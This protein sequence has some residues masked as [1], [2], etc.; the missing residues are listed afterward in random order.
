MTRDS[1]AERAA[2][3][4]RRVERVYAVLARIYDA[5]FDWALGPGRR[6]AI[7]RLPLRPGDR[8][9]E[10]GVGTGLSL[11]HYPADC[12]VTGI[13]ISEPM[14][15]QARERA[16]ELR[17]SDVDLRLMDARELAFADATFDHVLAPYVM[18]V[19]PQPERVMQEMRRVCKPEGTIA[20]VNHFRSENRILGVLERVFTPASQWI[21]F[22]MDLPV[23]VV[24][25]APGLRVE[26]V[27]KVNLLRHWQ[28]LV[29]S[30][31]GA[32]RGARDPVGDVDQ[33]PDES[34]GERAVAG[35]AAG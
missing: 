14:L 18:S 31:D 19:V 5:F 17:R 11:L 6:R 28:L 16:A 9:L 35:S 4:S 7:H 29:L 27:E 32:E 34:E 10:V 2:L 12:H 24:S 13:D 21:G 3:E 1:A 26:Q 33:E 30:P 22:R 23:E 25:E 15:E 20:V 8:V